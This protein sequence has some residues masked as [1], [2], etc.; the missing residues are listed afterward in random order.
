M[1]NWLQ[2]QL[3]SN[4]QPCLPKSWSSITIVFDNADLEEMWDIA[5][6]TIKLVKHKHLPKQLFND[7]DV[8]EVASGFLLFMN[9]DALKKYSALE[10]IIQHGFEILQ[11]MLS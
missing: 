5:S 9:H 4:E 3:L 1:M 7:I 8:Y 11:G 10:L 2:K 6:Y